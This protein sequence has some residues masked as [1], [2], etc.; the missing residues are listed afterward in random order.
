MK[1]SLESISRIRVI[2]E[3]RIVNLTLGGEEDRD[4][5]DGRYTILV[6]NSY[7]PSYFK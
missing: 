6:E 2:I 5:D 4:G 7:C 3:P 1:A